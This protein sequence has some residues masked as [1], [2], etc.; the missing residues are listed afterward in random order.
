[1]AFSRN[2]IVAWSLFVAWSIY[3]LVLAFWLA[4]FA[5]QLRA[6]PNPWVALAAYLFANPAYLLIIVGAVYVKT[7]F[8]GGKSL[9]NYV[10]GF[11]SGVLL[12][13]A[14][15]FVSFPHCLPAT[16]AEWSAT[17]ISLEFCSDYFLSKPF[18]SGGAYDAIVLFYYVVLPIVFVFA[19]IQLMGE[20]RFVANVGKKMR[21]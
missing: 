11:V 10:K 21:G 19:A 1:M 17:P 12:T 2:S 13:A 5:A 7:S 20:D 18:I 3:V 6:D 8:L 9:A 4:P 16:F 15:D 14:M